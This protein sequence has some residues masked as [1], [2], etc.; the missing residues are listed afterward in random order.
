MQPVMLDAAGRRRSPATL[1]GYARGRPPRNKGVQYPADPPS[2]EEIISVM[3]CAGERPE[4]LR[5]RA[6]IVV[7]WRAGLRISEALALAESDLT[8]VAERS[9]CAVERAASA[10]KS[11]WTPGPGNSS[12]PGLSCAGRCPSAPC[13]VS[14]TGRPAVGRGQ[15]PPRERNCGASRHAQVCA[16]D[17]RPISC[18]TPTPLRWHAKTSHW[19]SSS[20]SSAMATWASRRS[21]SKAS[22]AVR[23]SIP[24]TPAEPR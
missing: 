5:M 14:S 12:R 22:T 16:G 1:P 17:L 10:A 21:I 24:S 18:D 7:L 19:S 4:G 2:V 23:S 13:C 9:W 6:L 8:R 20:A 11:A 3:R 15:R